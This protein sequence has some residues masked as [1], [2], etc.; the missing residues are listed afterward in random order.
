MIGVFWSVLLDVNLL[1]SPSKC[2]ENLSTKHLA[3]NFSLFKFAQGVSLRLQL[4]NNKDKIYPVRS[5]HSF[6]IY[7]I[8]FR[9]CNKMI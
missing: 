3:S 8:K 1:I 5:S 9:M 2:Q 6:R 4:I 7:R